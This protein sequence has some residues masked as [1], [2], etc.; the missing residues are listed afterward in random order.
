M[1]KWMPTWEQFSR[2]SL[3][4]KATY[5]GFVIA[6]L[7]VPSLGLLYWDS[8]SSL[9]SSFNRIEM[10]IESAA[11]SEIRLSVTNPKFRHVVISNAYFV[12]LFPPT[13]KQ[14]FEQLR[15]RIFTYDGQSYPAIIP[16]QSTTIVAVNR[17][18]ILPIPDMNY[19]AL[20]FHKYYIDRFLWSLA[21]NNQSG[22]FFTCAI[23]LLTEDESPIT[24]ADDYR[25]Q[26]LNCEVMLAITGEFSP[27]EYGGEKYTPDPPS[28]PRSGRRGR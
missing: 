8:I 11:G 5:I 9:N 19:W 3:P 17:Q 26:Y 14:A 16:K 4:S 2:W 25:L 7:S 28:S 27:Y 22:S 10:R 21:Q 13:Y 15:I 1:L 20:A 6:V 24:T 12:A 18:S 23:Y